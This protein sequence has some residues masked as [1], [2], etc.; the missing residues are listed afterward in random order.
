M[1]VGGAWQQSAG[2][3][4]WGGL[5]IPNLQLGK[6][7]LIKAELTVVKQLVSGRVGIPMM[8]DTIVHIL[9]HTKVLGTEVL[10]FTHFI[11]FLSCISTPHPKHISFN[12]FEVR[13]IIMQN[14]ITLLTNK[15]HLQGRKCW[16]MRQGRGVTL[17][18]TN[19][20]NETTDLTP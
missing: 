17:C 9:N 12:F 16:R 6:W 18:K 10:S 5:I 15:I 11:P 13:S 2:V 1:G 7:R 4:T 20:S 3:T 8:S 14:M 19:K